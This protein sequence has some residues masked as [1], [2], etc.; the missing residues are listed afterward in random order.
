M[1]KFE[2]LVP[3]IPL[4][5]P[6][7]LN[8]KCLKNNIVIETGGI[9]GILGLR[10]NWSRIPINIWESGTFYFEREIPLI[11]WESGI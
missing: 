2:N 4:I 8:V 11:I 5:P 3:L 6:I 1:W 9:R 7:L 10:N